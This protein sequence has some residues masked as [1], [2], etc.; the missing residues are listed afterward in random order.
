MNELNQS[1]LDSI[2]EDGEIVNRT[3]MQGGVIEQFDVEYDG[4]GYHM[5]REF[6]VWTYFH[7]YN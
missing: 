5:T 2:F 3:I 1:L 7:R 6:G 4:H